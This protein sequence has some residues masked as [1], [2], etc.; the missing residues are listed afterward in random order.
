MLVTL[1]MLFVAQGTALGESAAE[2]G[3]G[4]IQPAAGKSDNG[5]AHGEEK[6][7]EVEIVRVKPIL[8]QLPGPGGLRR[9]IAITLSLEVSEARDRDE[10]IDKRPKL[11]ARIFEAWAAP[12]LTR[13][14]A[15]N[16]DLEAV[17]QR[18]LRAAD[19]LFGEGVVTSVLIEEVQEVLIR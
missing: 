13:D 10:V 14:G 11:R 18:A 2:S 5:E 8:I 9:S 7:G 17:K 4:W 15:E 16:V 1:M 19:R 12:P 3:P 6:A